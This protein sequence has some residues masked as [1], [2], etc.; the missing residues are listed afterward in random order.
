[1]MHFF[2]ILVLMSVYTL[3]TAQMYERSPIATSVSLQGNNLFLTDVLS[4]N[5]AYCSLSDIEHFTAGYEFASAPIAP[6]HGWHTLALAIPHKVATAG[7][8]INH[9]SYDTYR[10][11]Q[12]GV[13]LGRSFG[14]LQAGANITAFR[15]AI[16]HY[17]ARTSIIPSI[18]LKYNLSK[19]WEL[20]FHGFN[21]FASKSDEAYTQRF[22]WTAT[23]GAHYQPQQ[24]VHLYSFATLASQTYRLIWYGS[25]RYQYS[26]KFHLHTGFAT[27]GQYAIGIGYR[28]GNLLTTIQFNWRQHVGISPSGSFIYEPGHEQHVN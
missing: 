5:S 27:S 12:F 9:F 1:M 16:R 24:Q 4:A 19:K 7:V 10:Q 20:G 8:F 26:E 17:G 11:E 25:F 23:M 13:S 15:T 21:T 3:S 28:A 18:A 6:Q 22:S 2:Y 14:P